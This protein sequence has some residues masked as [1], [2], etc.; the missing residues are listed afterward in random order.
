MSYHSPH[1]GRH[2][3]MPLSPTYVVT[4]NPDGHTWSATGATLTATGAT[5]VDALLALIT[6]ETTT[7]STSQHSTDAARQRGIRDAA[8]VLRCHWDGHLPID[9][10]ALADALGVDTL[11][12]PLEPRLLGAARRFRAGGTIQVDGGQPRLRRR[13]AVAHM[14]AHLVD[15]RD[16][17]DRVECGRD[18]RWAVDECEAYARAFSWHLLMPPAVVRD[19]AGRGLGEGEVA[20]AVGVPLSVLASHAAEL[21]GGRSATRGWGCPG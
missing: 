4:C 8:T 9:P 10:V 3:R 17:R 21:G 16:E 1:P 19:L 7:P 5:P 12:R 20:R 14:L 6:K 18:A 11:T 13:V 2:Q 15:E